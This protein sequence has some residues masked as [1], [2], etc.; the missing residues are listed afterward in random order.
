MS[1]Q[2]IRHPSSKGEDNY[3]LH[4]FEFHINIVNIPAC[5]VPLIR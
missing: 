4:N 1:S 5:K 2:F 3:Y